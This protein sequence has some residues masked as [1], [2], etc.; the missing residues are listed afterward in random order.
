[1]HLHP[2]V[3]RRFI[4]HY[5]R[6]R[7]LRKGVH[8]TGGPSSQAGGDDAR[9]KAGDGTTR[10]K[11]LAREAVPHP[12]RLGGS[13]L[14][15]RYSLPEMAALWSDD[16]KYRTWLEVEVLSVEAWS[17]LG[18]IPA[19]Y[20][21]AV[22]SRANFDTAAVHEREKV[23]EHDVAAFVDVV[24][25]RVGRPA[26][27]WVHYG[28]TSSDVVDTSLALTL[29]RAAGVQARTSPSH[30]ASVGRVWV[31]DYTELLLGDGRGHPLPESVGI[32]VQVNRSR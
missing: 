29:T 24:A 17:V 32:G 19:E 10:V 6:I 26:G 18:V 1:M 28:L 23:T 13:S 21:A 30:M 20:A 11:Q 7:T 31:G 25:E 3:L 27:A 4:R 8:W 22:R 5:D 16:A 12:Y 9:L 15:H 2:R 14:I